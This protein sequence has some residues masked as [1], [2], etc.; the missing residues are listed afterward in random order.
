MRATAVARERFHQGPRGPPAAF[1]FSKKTPEEK[2]IDPRG[3]RPT[4]RHYLRGRMNFSQQAKK[5]PELLPHPYTGAR[6]KK[7]PEEKLEL[8]TG[9]NFESFFIFYLLFI[10]L[11]FNR[12]LYV[13]GFH[14]SLSLPLPFF[15]IFLFSENPFSFSLNIPKQQISYLCQGEASQ[16]DVIEL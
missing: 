5:I 10:I 6:P 16:D 9:P 7:T 15:F 1:F 2:K 11:L 13:L 4:T 8:E 3:V 12:F 14:I